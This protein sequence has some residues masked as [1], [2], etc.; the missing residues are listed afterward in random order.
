MT[1]EQA[2][3]YHYATYTARTREGFFI[4]GAL[5]MR[6]KLYTA[7]DIYCQREE[8]AGNPIRVEQHKIINILRELIT[9]C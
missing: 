7:L 8:D 4:D 3:K 2:A 6:G 9:D 1:I 5:W